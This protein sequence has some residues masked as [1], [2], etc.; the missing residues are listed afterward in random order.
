M[1]YLKSLVIF[2]FTKVY[3]FL[4]ILKPPL[5]PEKPSKEIPYKTFAA[6]GLTKAE[7]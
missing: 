1:S 7:I 2:S 5:S 3:I 4:D 6:K